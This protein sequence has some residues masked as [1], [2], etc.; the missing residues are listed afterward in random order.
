M[1]EILY[2]LFFGDPSVQKAIAPL[3][4]AA[5]AAAPGVI[6]AVG[7][8]FGG[9][10]RRREEKRAAQELAARKSTYENF[11]FK[12]PSANLTNTFEDLT[13]NQQQANFAS[14]QQ[15][16]GLASTLSGLSGA[17]GGSG[18]AALAQSL[19]QQQSTN[20]QQ[21]SASIGAQEQQNQILSAQGQQSLQQARAEGQQVKEAKE[22]GR[23]ETLLDSAAQRKQRATAARAQAKSDLVGGIAEAAGAAGSALTGGLGKGGGGGGGPQ[24]PTGLGTSTMKNYGQSFLDKTK[25]MT[26]FKIPNLTG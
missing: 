8:L 14:Q 17:A 20:L 2:K 15:Q 13:V 22:F 25:G 3:A 7:S 5:A 24:M 21:A 4:M 16:Q 10:K 11:E 1:E 12:D 9:G 23:V 6:K 19:A 18:I 26:N